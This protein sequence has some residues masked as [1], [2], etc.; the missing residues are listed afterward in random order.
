MDLLYDEKRDI[1]RDSTDLKKGPAHHVTVELVDTALRLTMNQASTEPLTPEAA[2]KL[3]KKIDKH[4]LPLMMIC[5]C[6]CCCIVPDSDFLSQCILFNLW[7][8][9]HWEAVPFLA[10]ERTHSWTQISELCL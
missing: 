8:R 10:S 2:L 4:L 1:E 3:R 7:T 9:L 5:W 6:T